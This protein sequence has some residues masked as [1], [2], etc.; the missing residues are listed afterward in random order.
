[1]ARACCGKSGDLLHPK[2]ATITS[3]PRLAVYVGG[4]FIA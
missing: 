2:E 4:D 3:G 1:M